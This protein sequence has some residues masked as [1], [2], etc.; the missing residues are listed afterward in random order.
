L[1]AAGELHSPLKMLHF[2]MGP[3]DTVYCIADFPERAREIMHLHKRAQLDLVRTMAEAHVPAMMSM[4]NLDT[5]FHPPAYVRQFCASYYEQA[6]ALCHRSG[7]T[8]FIHACGQ[9]RETLGLISSLGVDGLEGVAYPPLGDVQLEEAMGL[10]GDRFIITG[11]ISAMEF[12]NL[13]SKEEVFDYTRSLLERMRPYAN[14]YML[15]AS[16]NTPINAG[17]DAIRWFRDAWLDCGG[18]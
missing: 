1:V 14:R 9:Q 6:S 10:T 12:Q 5:L 2:A 18:F 17:W 13:H 8:L 4:D 15:S 3:I 7:S 11:G 16:C